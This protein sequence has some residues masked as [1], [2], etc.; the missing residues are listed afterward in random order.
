VTGTISQLIGTPSYMAPEQL[1][2]RVVGPR[3]DVF[4][5]GTTIVFAATGR[6][7]FGVDSIPAVM[8]RIIHDQ[9]DL[10]ALPDSLRDV[11]RA[12]LAKDPVRRPTAQQ[13]LLWLVDR[14][15]PASPHTPDPMPTEARS[16]ASAPHAAA[17]PGSGHINAAARPSTSD[18]LIP[19]IPG[20]EAPAGT[21][22]SRS[23]PGRAAGAFN[24]TLVVLVAALIGLIAGAALILGPQLYGGDDAGKSGSDRPTRTNDTQPPTALGRPQGGIPAAFGGIWNG[25]ARNQNGVAFP[26]EVTFQNGQQ[27]AQVTYAGEAHCTT[28]LTLISSAPDRIDMSLA[29]G[30]SCTPGTVRIQT[31]ADGR[32]DYAFTSTSGRYAIQA[33]L[34]RT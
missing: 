23:G 27:T 10:A 9:P 13:L 14:E 33:V 11:V 17:A 16:A 5:W 1:T 4:A 2:D 22:P 25:T 15:G 7:A 30:P 29:P 3:A 31:R 21:R 8:H 19:L 24:R 34:S 18:P 32:L 28:T 6:P 26:A 12:A 20:F